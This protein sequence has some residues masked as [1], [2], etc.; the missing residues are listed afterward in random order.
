MSDELIHYN[1]ARWNELVKAGVMYSRPYLELNVE[2]AN[3][4]V[5]P[6]GMMDPVQG[7]RVLCLAA[8]GGQQSAAFGLLGAEVTVLDFSGAQL[9]RDQ[10]A[11]AHY[12]LQA[13]LVLGDMRDLSRFEDASFDLIW[14]AYS[15]NFVPDTAPVF[16]EVARVLRPGGQYRVEWS[17]PFLNGVEGSS[18]NGQGYL[19][20]HVYQD[21]EMRFDSAHW[22]IE[23]VDGVVREVEGPREFN[24][25]LSTVVNGLIGRGFQLQGIWEERSGDPH[26]EPGSWAHFLAFVPP[27]LTLWARYRP[28]GA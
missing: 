8:G 1:Q 18:W 24:H 11:L 3:Q 27:Y 25:T 15:I 6:Q 26:A 10:E 28:A 20:K 21:G 12:G 17:N 7:R 5:N 14:H 23:G 9:E 22:S 19:L 2:A 16:D 4:V 13:R